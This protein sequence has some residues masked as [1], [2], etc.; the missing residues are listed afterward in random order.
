ML[1]PNYLEHTL[2]GIAMLRAFM[3]GTHGRWKWVAPVPLLPF[4]MASAYLIYGF[5][6]Y[7]FG[8]ANIGPLSW[9]K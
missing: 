1:I 8:L 7:P 4:G 3:A 6:A 5:F 9:D 2:A